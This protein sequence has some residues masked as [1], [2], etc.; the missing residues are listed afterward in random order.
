MNALTQGRIRVPAEDLAAFCR[1]HHIR[2]LSLFGSVLREDF[3]PQSDIDVL[4]EFEPGKVP[5]L[6]F[7]RMKD[8]LS[9]LLGRRV[10][11]NTPRSLSPHFRDEVLREAERVYGAA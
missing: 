3:G 5:G 10:D 7:V 9:R 4:I 11:L 6:E 2:S 8:E 1:R